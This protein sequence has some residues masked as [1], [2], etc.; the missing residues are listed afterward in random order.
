MRHQN[1]VQTVPDC[2]NKLKLLGALRPR[3]HHSRS[4]LQL[5]KQVTGERGLDAHQPAS[6]VD[7]LDFQAVVFERARAVRNPEVAGRTAQWVADFELSQ[8]GSLG[9]EKHRKQELEIAQ[10]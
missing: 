7:R 5:Q 2:A 8:L 3:S 10:E 4:P 6:D 9:K 1:V